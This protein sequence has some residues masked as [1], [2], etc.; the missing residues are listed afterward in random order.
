MFYDFFLLECCNCISQTSAMYKLLLPFFFMIS[1]LS[2]QSSESQY[3]STSDGLHLNQC[4]QN[5]TEIIN[6]TTQ[7]KLVDMEIDAAYKVHYAPVLAKAKIIAQLTT[8]VYDSITSFQQQIDLLP[9]ASVINK[10]QLTT[11]HSLQQKA[12]HLQEKSIA[13]VYKSWDNGGIKGTIFRDS[14]RR[15]G[16]IQYIKKEIRPI[17]I[18][19]EEKMLSPSI[20]P[21]LQT[22]LGLLQQQVKQNE[23]VFIHFFAGQFGKMMLCGPREFMAINSAKTCIRLGETYEAAFIFLLEIP[24]KNYDVSIG[25]SVLNMVDDRSPIYSIPSTAKGEQCFWTTALIENP[26]TKEQTILRKAFYFEVTQ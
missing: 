11:F 8:A 22:K 21:I 25:D 6:K 7:A 19:T 2:C 13:L 15:K 26:L 1:G 3:M 4:I 17:L 23:A 5:S 24:H 9:L 20:K 14:T 10:E 12:Q 18:T 16:S